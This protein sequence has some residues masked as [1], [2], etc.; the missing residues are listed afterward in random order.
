MRLGIEKYESMNSRENWESNK[1]RKTNN[2]R[3]Y[4]TQT[5]IVILSLY[6]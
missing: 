3:R 5:Q 6:I 2:E 4:T 1:K